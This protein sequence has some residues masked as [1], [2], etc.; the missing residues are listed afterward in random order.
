MTRLTIP[1]AAGFACAFATDGV[2]LEEGVDYGGDNR[3]VWVRGPWEMVTPS[4]DI[5]D[6]IDQLCP[7]V[8]R[9]PDAATMM[10]SNTADCCT[11]VRTK[12][13]TRVRHRH[14]PVRDGGHRPARLAECLAW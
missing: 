11:R 8:M 9:L 12:G 4:A 7:A 6:V 2:R 1:L 13:T 5:D 14:F 10:A 3:S